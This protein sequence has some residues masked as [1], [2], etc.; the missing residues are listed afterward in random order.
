MPPR[1]TIPIDVR[2][3]AL[4]KRTTDNSCWEWQG[5]RNEERGGYGQFSPEHGFDRRAHRY[6][7][8]LTFGPIPAGLKV[9]H[10]CDNPPCCR[11]DHLFLGTT[12]HNVAD[13]VR[14]G[15]SCR[16]EGHGLTTLTSEQVAEIRRRV[17][18]AP[19]GKSGGTRHGYGMRDLATEFGVSFQTVLNIVHR[20]TW[21][22]E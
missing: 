7:W 11:P 13:K 21:I 16:G 3:W 19:K 10:H 17:A 5:R 8:E 14:K 12:A 18:T 9:C 4:V 15:R 20:K 1:S 6:A 2:F 22:Y